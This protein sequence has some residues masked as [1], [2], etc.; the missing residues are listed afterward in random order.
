MWTL[1]SALILSILL[2]PIGS[3]EARTFQVTKTADTDDGSCDTDCSLR[4]AIEAANARV[5]ADDVPV[6][7]GTYLLTLGQLLVSDDVGIAGA[8]QE[9]TIIDGNAWGRV[10]E[11]QSSVAAEISGAT[12]Q[13][14]EALGGGGIYNRG[15]LTLTNSTVSGNAIPYAGGGSGGGIYNSAGAL[16]L[17]NTTVSENTIGAYGYGAG[18]ANGFGGTATLTDSMVSGNTAYFGGGIS[19][20]DYATLTLTNSTVS[21]NTAIYDGGGIFNHD[22]ATLTLTNSTVSGNSTEYGGGGGIYNWRSYLVLAK[23]TVSLNTAFWAG[24]GII[25][26]E[27][28]AATLTNSTVSG[29]YASLSSGGIMNRYSTASLT[30]STVSGND[31]WEPFAGNGIN[32]INSS[33]TITNSVVAYNWISN[34]GLPV[35]S[36]GYNLTDDTSCGFSATGDLVVADAMLGP[37][38]DNGGP[39]ETHDLLPGSPAIDAGSPSCPPPTTDQRGVTR[40]RGAACD[41]GAV[42]YVPEPGRWFMLVTGTLFLAGLS[43]RRTR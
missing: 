15:D 5:G 43:R 7:A 6:P 17:I 29:N 10:F 12:I 20:H 26:A 9:S 32:D 13:N 30:N 14:G 8:G 23:S 21:G 25:N 42:E 18:I 16:T 41:I 2:L 35:Y 39:T 3:L 24:G 4:E 11:I 33:T 40:P 27:Y 28:S 22:Y 36:L 19:N 38:A 34:C 31:A 37:L 1:R